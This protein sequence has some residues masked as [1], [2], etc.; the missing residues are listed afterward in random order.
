M[1]LK[2][3]EYFEN[4]PLRLRGNN[5]CVQI[6]E[7][8]LIHNV[9]SH[10][11]RST[12]QLTW[13]ITLVDISINPGLGY[14]QVVTGRSSETLIPVIETALRNKSLIYTRKW[15]AYNPQTNKDCY[16]YKNMNRNKIL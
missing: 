1:T 11:G 4:N 7:T 2:S 15:E 10:R 9:K 14:S 6:D 13:A 16:D 3:Q 5:K 12:V 8:E